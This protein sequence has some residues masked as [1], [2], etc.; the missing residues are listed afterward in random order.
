M[1]ISAGAGT[2]QHGHRTPGV[3]LFAE[4]AP[5]R[6]A[7]SAHSSARS[8]QARSSKTSAAAMVVSK[9]PTWTRRLVPGAAPFA[10]HRGKARHHGGDRSDRSHVSRQGELGEAVRSQRSRWLVAS[11]TVD[12]EECRLGHGLFLAR[13]GSGLVRPRRSSNWLVRFDVAVA[14]SIQSTGSGAP[15]RQ[16]HSSGVSASRA[17][18]C[19]GAGLAQAVRIHSRQGGVEHRVLGVLDRPVRVLDGELGVFLG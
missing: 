19:L 12:H 6:R 1:T 17:A 13:S 15:P 4:S 5:I 3:P 9:Y 8:P 18:R 16:S 11:A 10:Q 2:A 7:S 14:C